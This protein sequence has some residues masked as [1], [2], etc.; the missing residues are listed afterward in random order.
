MNLN[1]LNTTITS[2]FSHLSQNELISWAAIGLGVV[3]MIVG[4]LLL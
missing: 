3:L 2:Y 1:Q 4:L